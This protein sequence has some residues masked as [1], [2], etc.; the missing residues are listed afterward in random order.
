MV[1]MEL[2]GA[3]DQVGGPDSPEFPK[4]M[5]GVPQELPIAP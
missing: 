4:G 1:Q 3:V 2:P 5:G